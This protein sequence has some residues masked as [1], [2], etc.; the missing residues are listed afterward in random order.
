MWEK[1]SAESPIPPQETVRPF[2]VPQDPVE[3]CVIGSTIAIKGEVSGSQDLLINGRIEGRRLSLGGHGVIVG[4]EGW[5]KADILAR[6]IRIEGSVQGVLR[7]EEKI[8]L[9]RTGTV[10]G[11]LIAP[12]VVLEE[13]C[14]FRGSI[15]MGAGAQS[16]DE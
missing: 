14:K 4:R 11:K 12:R 1:D 15:N 16:S 10:Q 8:L 9:V 3:R 6:V 5:V 13:G 7:A 2:A